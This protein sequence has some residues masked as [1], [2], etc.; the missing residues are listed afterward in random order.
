M[1]FTHSSAS[2]TLESIPYDKEVSILPYLVLV[3][4]IADSLREKYR[5]IIFSSVIGTS[6]S[7]LLPYTLYDGKNIRKVTAYRKILSYFSVLVKFYG[8]IGRFGVGI[9]RV[10]G[11]YSVLMTLMGGFYGEKSRANL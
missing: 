9:L 4:A 1:S 10:A 11:A 5:S 6:P 8:I 2:G 7:A 3:S